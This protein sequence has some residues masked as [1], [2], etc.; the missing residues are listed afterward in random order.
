MGQGLSYVSEIPAYETKCMEWYEGLRMGNN[1]YTCIKYRESKQLL[2]YVLF[3]ITSKLFSLNQEIVYRI[4]HRS[5]LN[6]NGS[7]VY[8]LGFR[9]S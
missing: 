7:N 2:Y 4:Q 9:F 5:G 6:K 3:E 8:G 1:I